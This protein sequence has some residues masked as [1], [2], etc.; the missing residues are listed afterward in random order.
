MSF[1]LG[2]MQVR[3]RMEELISTFL[4]VNQENRLMQEKWTHFK[5]NIYFT[6][7]RSANSIRSLNTRLKIN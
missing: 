6:S 7:F 5:F 2:L 1:V 4:L 3:W